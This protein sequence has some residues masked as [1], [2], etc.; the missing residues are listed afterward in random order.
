[1]SSAFNRSR[2]AA[3]CFD[4]DGTLADTDDAYVHRIARWL[5][6]FPWFVPQRDVDSVAR[7]LV[8]RAET[9]VNA[10]LATLDRLYLDQV[11]GPVFG[12]LHLLRGASS[13]N[14]I[15]LVPGARETLE[16]LFN[17]YPLGIVT[18]REHASAHAVL[19]EHEIEGYFQCIATARSALRAKPHPAPVRWAADQI[20]VPASE[21]LMVGDT[22]V[23]ILAGRAAGSQTAAL[24]CGFGERYEL[25]QA[26]ADIIL[27]RPLQLVDVLLG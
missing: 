27:E 24:L 20:G 1:M 26:G 12:Q 19:Q 23:D 14:S 16:G 7:R 2:I 5:R 8:L 18:A 4:I 3:V 11:L 9:P 13:R 15:P 6:Y 21:L 10:L 22:A 25:E 17:Y